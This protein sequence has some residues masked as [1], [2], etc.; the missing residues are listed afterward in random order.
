MNNNHQRETRISRRLSHNEQQ[1]LLG[2]L[3]RIS[4]PGVDESGKRREV[5]AYCRSQGIQESSVWALLALYRQDGCDAV[6]R[7]D[8]EQLSLSAR[9]REKLRSRIVELIGKL[10]R[11]TLED[12]M[13]LLA[14]REEFL[15]RLERVSD[16][17][18]YF[19]LEREKGLWRESQQTTVYTTYFNNKLFREFEAINEILGQHPEIREVQREYYS[20]VLEQTLNEEAPL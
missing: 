18:V 1:R 11:R 10:P 14:F 2:V 20:W 8:R 13:S 5:V 6:G 16:L 19:F 12:F 15:E 9:Q 17:L 4:D 7:F 3:Q